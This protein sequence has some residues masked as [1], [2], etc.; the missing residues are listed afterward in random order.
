M[1]GSR[2]PSPLARTPEAERTALARGDEEFVEFATASSAGLRHAA[3]LLTGDGHAAEEAVQTALVRTYAA[4]SR[5]RRDDAF[6]YA[7]RTLVNYVTDRWRRKLKEYPTDDLPEHP[8]GPDIADEVALRQWVTGALATLT[9]R[10]RAVIVLRYLFDL[11][12]AAVARDLGIT[13]GTVKSTSSRA[14]AKLRVSAEADNSGGRARWPPRDA[15][16]ER[17]EG[18]GHERP[19]HP[20]AQARPPRAPGARIPVTRPR[21]SGRRRRD[22]H[23]GTAAPL[24]PPGGGRGRQR[25]PRR[26]RVRRGGRNRQ[27]DH[28]VIGSGPA[29]GQPGRPR[30]HSPAPSPSPGRGRATPSP[31]PSATATPTTPPSRVAAPSDAVGDAA[32][33]TAAPTATAPASPTQSQTPTPTL[34]AGASVSGEYSATSTPSASATGADGKQPSPTAVPSAVVR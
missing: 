13:A 30:P 11:P 22:H 4:W 29:C 31:V 15:R 3:Y 2:P 19:R 33:P 25:L 12:E 24:A 8:A 10:E 26:R 34:T 1:G 7:R 28:A 32:P 23:P 14:L 9:A 20:A 16:P 18:S 27:A 21:R 17:S 6:A 5:V